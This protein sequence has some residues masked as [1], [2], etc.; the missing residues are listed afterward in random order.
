MPGKARRKY[1]R[2]DEAWDVERCDSEHYLS[3]WSEIRF[4]SNAADCDV[5]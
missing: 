4:V 2:L 3:S 1:K 5:L